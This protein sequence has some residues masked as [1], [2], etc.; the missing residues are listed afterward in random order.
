MMWLNPFMSPAL[1]GETWIGRHRPI[2][3]GPIVKL[4]YNTPNLASVWRHEE[5]DE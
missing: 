2:N 1:D 5:T 4:S 3:I